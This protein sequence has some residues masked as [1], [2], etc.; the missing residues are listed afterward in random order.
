MQLQISQSDVATLSQVDLANYG[1][2]ER[3]IGNPTIQ[4]L[5]QLAVTLELEPGELLEGLVDLSLLPEPEH[6]F[7]S[8]DFVREQ[9]L[10]RGRPERKG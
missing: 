3:G 2:V 4:T 5:L 7:S 9:L 10:S 8:T 1:R 6:T